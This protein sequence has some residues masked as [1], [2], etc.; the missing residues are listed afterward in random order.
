MTI[1]PFSAADEFEHA[2][3]DSVVVFVDIAGFTAFTEAHGDHRAA[4]LADRFA[5]IAARVLGP[6][7]EMIKTLGDAVMIT[8]SDPTAALAFLRRLHEQT[9]RI[10]GFPLLRAGICAG[11]VVKRRGD[12]FGS[13]VNTAARLAAVARPGQIVG[14]ADAASALRGTDLLATTSLGS[15]RLRN[16]G[17]LVE[18]FALDVGTRHQEHVDPICRMHVSTDAQSLTITHEEDTYRFYFCST[19]CL[20]QFADRVGDMSTSSGDGDSQSIQS[21]LGEVAAPLGTL[22][23]PTSG[24]GAAPMSTRSTSC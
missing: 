4:E 20:R 2:D 19:A 1:D 24:R 14:N 13:T 22:R 16:V 8:S 7:D 6:G 15:L 18:A 5:T 21:F 11:A 10:D 17:A 23:S 3:V 9:R 12:V